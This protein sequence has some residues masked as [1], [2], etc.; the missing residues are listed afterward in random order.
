VSTAPS[1]A[2]ALLARATLLSQ[3]R[4]SLLDA[5]ICGTLPRYLLFRL[6]PFL[7]YRLL[8]LLAH[9]AELFLLLRLFPDRALIKSVVLNNVCALGAVFFWAALEPARRAAQ[10]APTRA[11]ASA[12]ANPY[13][14]VTALLSLLCAGWSLRAL[15]ASRFGLASLYAAALLVRLLLDLLTRALQIP[16]AA[17]TRVFRPPALMLLRPLIAPL[18]LV[19]YWDLL[20]ARSLPLSV[21][22][23]ALAQFAL[24]AWFTLRAYRMQRTPVP[25]PRLRHLAQ[26]R[27]AAPLREQLAA[28]LAYALPAVASL[29]LCAL[30]VIGAS[31]DSHRSMLVVLH[32]MLPLLRTRPTG[33]VS[34]GSALVIRGAGAQRP[35]R[36][37]RL[38]LLEIRAWVGVAKRGAAIDVGCEAVADKL[39]S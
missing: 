1:R 30:I 29:L 24:A 5:L 14:G 33:R 31:R 10:R 28:G 4:P 26:L 19:L 25:A 22:V 3:R 39:A 13:L 9:L 20:G 35:V 11:D 6:R 21:A 27:R 37:R 18:V 32:A 38:R 2:R 7:V 34:R 12:L 36:E 23:A 15:I 8:G 16:I 17:Q